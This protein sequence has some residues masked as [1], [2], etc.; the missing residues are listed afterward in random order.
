MFECV[1]Y[2]SVS[3]PNDICV[4]LHGFHIAT[5]VRIH[6]RQST[7]AGFD[8]AKHVD[9][10]L[11]GL[12]ALFNDGIKSLSPVFSTVCLRVSDLFEEFFHSREFMTHHLEDFIQLPP[13]SH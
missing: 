2:F 13:F 10:G 12:R 3:I 1:T 4:S 8:R 9:N 5:P 6:D 11:L 7:F